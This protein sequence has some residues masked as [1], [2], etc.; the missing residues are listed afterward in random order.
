[1]WH[2]SHIMSL[3]IISRPGER[4]HDTDRPR[5][6]RNSIVPVATAMMLYTAETSTLLSSDTSNT[7]KMS[8]MKMTQQ[9]KPFK[10][11]SLR[12]SSSNLTAISFSVDHVQYCYL[13]LACFHLTSTSLALS[14]VADHLILLS[15]NGHSTWPPFRQGTRAARKIKAEC[16]LWIPH[17]VLS[18]QEAGVKRSIMEPWR[19][20][21]AQEAVLPETLALHDHWRE[22]L[23]L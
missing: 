11:Q 10:A 22:I 14:D 18:A 7:T 23:L 2:A 6:L 12:S 20:P 8:P 3:Q 13:Y 9:S 4:A 16:T 5:N 1:M 21:I 15:T 19:T 17:L